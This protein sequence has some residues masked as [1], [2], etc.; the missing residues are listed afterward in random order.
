MIKR[1]ALIILG[2]CISL[3]ACGKSG[4]TQESETAVNEHGTETVEVIE[5]AKESEGAEEPKAVKESEVVEE[6]E[7][8]E[9]PM[10]QITDMDGAVEEMVPAIEAYLD[11]AYMDGYREFTVKNTDLYWGYVHNYCMRNGSF[12]DDY[13]SCVVSRYEIEEV[14]RAA[15]SDFTD[16]PDTLHEYAAYSPDMLDYYAVEDNYVKMPVGNPGEYYKAGGWETTEDGQECNLV[17]DVYSY[18]EDDL[19]ATY[20]VHLRPDQ[21]AIEKDARLKFHITGI[22][23]L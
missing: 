10:K 8:D 4:S 3:T 15:F 23:K 19:V 18:A 2:L 21:E 16:I 13:Y 20:I 1:S 9:N 6:S 5:D 7:S 17:I 14:S 12:D 11:V 22:E